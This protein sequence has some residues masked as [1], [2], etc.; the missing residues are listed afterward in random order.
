MKPVWLIISV[1]SVLIMLPSDGLAVL[2]LGPGQYVQANGADITVPGYSVPSYVDFNNDGQKDLII[3]EGG[4]WKKP[5]IRVYLNHGTASTPQFSDYFYLT[6]SDGSSLTYV[7]QECI[8][9]AQGLFPRLLYWNHDTKKDLLVGQFDG[10]IRVYLNIGEDSNPVFD[11]GVFLRMG[12]P[13]SKVNIDVGDLA[14]P[15]VVDWDNDHNKDLAVGALDG[16][17]HLFLNQRNN[18]EPDFPLETFAQADG[19]DLVV[20]SLGSSPVVLDLDSDGKKDLLIG[21]SAGQLLFYSNVATDAEPAYSD[22][23]FIKSGGTRIKLDAV[24]GASPRARPFVCDWTN[25]GYL[26]VLIGAGNG[27]VYL[28]QGVPE[29]TTLLLLGL[30]GLGLL[31]KQP[32]K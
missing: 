10:T 20:H 9:S 25:D 3:G 17:I 13:G 6:K 5:G 16:K 8:C 24:T 18:T 26:D 15:T 22:H 19:Q 21:D 32:N 23:V 11:N 14:A 28:Y 4:N 31:I 27:K 1:L 2:N 12:Q 30:G 29:A 7:G